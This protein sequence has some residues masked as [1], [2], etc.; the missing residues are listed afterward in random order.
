MCAYFT[1]TQ[2][3]V[4]RDLLWN[5]RTVCFS[6]GNQSLRS[7]GQWETEAPQTYSHVNGESGFNFTGNRSWWC[8]TSGTPRHVRA[9]CFLPLSQQRPGMANGNTVDPFQG[10]DI[11][12][13]RLKYLLL[14]PG[15]AS[16]VRRLRK[17]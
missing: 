16:I 5:S 7:T 3:E 13:M 1:Q 8:S 15:P 4:A 6:T 11:W 12:I 10:K 2:G 17:L 9:T 14:L